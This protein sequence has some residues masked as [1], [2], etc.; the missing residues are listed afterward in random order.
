MYG[1]FPCR[2][3]EGQIHMLRCKY[4]VCLYVLPTF[5]LIYSHPSFPA[6]LHVG[7]ILQQKTFDE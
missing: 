1:W 4:Y 3:T 5:R 7:P 2:R 6:L